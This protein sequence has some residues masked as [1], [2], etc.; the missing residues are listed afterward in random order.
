[1]AVVNQMGGVGKTTTATNLAAALAIAEQTT[2]LI[3]ADPQA[4]TTRSLGFE[5][6]PQRPSIYDGLTG[7]ATFE[8]LRLACADLPHLTLIPSERDLVGL[9]IELVDQDHREFRMKTFLDAPR[10]EFRHVLIDC[11][12]SLGLITLNA[13]VAADAVLIPVQAEY[14]ALEG[15]SQLMDTITQV[16]EALNPRLEIDGVVM[17][18][19]DER[20]NLARQVV[21]EVRGFFG[22]QVY[23]TVVPRNVRLSEAPSHGK[24]IFLYDIRSRGA[25]AYLS[26]AKE[27]MAH[28]HDQAKGTGSRL[29]KPDPGHPA[30]EDRPGSGPSVRPP[31]DR[32]G[33]DPS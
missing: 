28:G 31:A 3:D 9:E 11:P 22:E 16:R 1:V 8:E 26:L 29:E 4:N 24:P 20:T 12:P 27:Y 14:L 7:L 19:F 21:D 2:L 25:D 15:M 10:T 32:P 13:L 23:R 18:M 5:Q 30:G 33:P 6:D 17:T